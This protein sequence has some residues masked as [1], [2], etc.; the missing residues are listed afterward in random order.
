[1]NRLVRFRQKHNKHR[2]GHDGYRF[3]SIL[4]LKAHCQ[5]SAQLP[6]DQDT[7]KPQPPKIFGPQAENAKDSQV[8][9]AAAGELR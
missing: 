4:S 1:M 3:W 8:R 2:E 7:N 9:K 6:I 5:P